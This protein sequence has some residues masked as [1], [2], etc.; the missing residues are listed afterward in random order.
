MSAI[1][2]S[3][4]KVEILD[5]RARMPRTI[6][7]T[8][9]GKQFERPLYLPNP[10]SMRITRFRTKH[11]LMP[12]ER[13]DGSKRKEEK[14][15][16]LLGAE[17]VKN[18]DLGDFKPLTKQ[19]IAEVE[20]V[21]KGRFGYRARAEIKLGKRKENPSDNDMV[22]TKKAKTSKAKL[23]VIKASYS[24]G[25]K[26]GNA[27]EEAASP[28]PKDLYREFNLWAVGDQPF[29]PGIYRYD[30][31]ATYPPYIPEDLQAPDEPEGLQALEPRLQYQDP[32]T[33]HTEASKSSKKPLASP[34]Q[35]IAIH[36]NDEFSQQN[37]LLSFQ[38]V[39]GQG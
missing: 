4:P 33:D 6:T 36:Q 10:L 16:S 34:S 2:L 7:V 23:S 19:E 28:S 24:D 3:D 17:R 37:D 22:P 31:G 14:L 21:N 1:F 29:V 35:P 38:D 30:P 32:V 9:K 18:N 26:S 5:I 20:A 12:R 15:K 27:F 8:E 11:G 13:R 39:P 25:I